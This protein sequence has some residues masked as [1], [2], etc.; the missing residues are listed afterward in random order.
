MFNWYTWRAILILTGCLLCACSSNGSSGSTPS[1]G[2]FAVELQRAFANLTFTLP[3]AM[4]QAPG[5]PTRFYV[6]EKDGRVRAFD[7]DPAAD[8][9]GDFF[10]DDNDLV[11]A[12]PNEAGLL[13]MAFHPDY[14][15]NS[16]VYL[17]YTRSGPVS[18]VSRYIVVG[19]SIDSNSEQ[20][21]II[22]NQPYGNHN[23]G[24][25][26]FGPDGYLYIGLGDGGS[27][28]DPHEHGQNTNTRLGAMLRIDVNNVP[29]G[30]DYG[31]PG[32]NPFAA[33]SGC[34]DA[35]CPEI[36]AW[37]LRN[38]WRWSFDRV[39]GDLW[40]G[41]VGQGN[42]EEVNLVRRGEN[43]GWRVREGAHCHRPANNCETAG[44]VDP[45]AEYGRSEGYSVTG[46]YVYRGSAIAALQGYYL[47]GDYGSGRIWALETGADNAEPVL[48]MDTNLNIASFAEDQVGEIYVLDYSSGEIHKLMPAP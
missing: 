27:G 19:G 36:Y 23:G 4:L 25:I 35:G 14:A 39:T 34:A 37:G 20:P 48:L 10:T 5:D 43:Y 21:V 1:G 41:D 3:V 15:G 45:R 17:S 2:D 47:Y 46:G 29:M 11:D 42:W 28:G 31:I 18:Y 8:T 30:A 40:L 44:F 33:S 13:G 16:T 38:P 32:D 9:T 24:Q 7:N 26:A 12:G 6:V 22:V